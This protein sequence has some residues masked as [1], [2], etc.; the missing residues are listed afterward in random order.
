MSVDLT[1]RTA[2]N[3]DR[4]AYVGHEPQQL[5]VGFERVQLLDHA[6][7]DAVPTATDHDQ[8]LPVQPTEQRQVPHD[9]ELG[10]G[11]RTAGQYDVRGAQF[12]HF[13]DALEQ[14]R[15]LQLLVEVRV[16]G[17][18]E[19]SGEQLD[20]YADHMATDEF[21]HALDELLSTDKTTAI[22]CAEAVP[23]RCHRNLVSDELVRRGHEVIHILNFGS[24]KK[25]EI[26]PFAH[27]AGG[28]L[29]YGN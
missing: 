10:E 4:R 15:G 5:Q 9:T 6:V 2:T 11:A 28:Y 26:S 3:F 20:G 17:A 14:G 23:W 8:R 7:Q 22:M 1:A 29:V 13:V 21:R 12:D 25:H 27:D 18:R 24:R 16:R 19:V